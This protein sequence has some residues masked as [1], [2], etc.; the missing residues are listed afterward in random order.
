MLMGHLF[1]CYCFLFKQSQ[2]FIPYVQWFYEII[3]TENTGI[4]KET[5]IL[6][7]HKL[8]HASWKCCTAA[9]IM[10]GE[11][12]ISTNK[13]QKL[14]F[15][16]LELTSY[17]MTYSR[18]SKEGIC[19]Y[20]SWK[21]II[22]CKLTEVLSVWKLRQAQPRT[23]SGL[24]KTRAVPSTVTGNV[25]YPHLLRKNCR[26]TCIYLLLP[27]LKLSVWKSLFHAWDINK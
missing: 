27:E 7:W 18:L 16:Q 24:D 25:S 10:Q 4:W 12:A 23:L 2:S 21:Q 14:S 9:F 20:R 19:I 17:R 26:H 15:M 8:Y 5:V 11:H 22:I 6:R 13:L 3:Y 1:M